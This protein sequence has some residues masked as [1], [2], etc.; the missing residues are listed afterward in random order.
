MNSFARLKRVTSKSADKTGK[1]GGVSTRPEGT[2]NQWSQYRLLKSLTASSGED[3]GCEG[4]CASGWVEDGS[5]SCILSIV[6]E[7]K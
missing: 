4:S 7:K 3:C 5:G 6:G 2:R 1:D